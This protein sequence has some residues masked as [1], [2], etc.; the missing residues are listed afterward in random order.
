MMNKIK[1]IAIA[2][3]A[4][5]GIFSATLISCNPDNCKNVVCANGGTCN[6]TD[7][8]CSCASGY[9]GTLCDSLSITK[10]IANYNVT[11]SCQSSYVASITTSS[12]ANNKVIISNIANL[13]TVNPGATVIATCDK[14]ALTITRQFVTG[15]S[16]TEVEGNGTISGNTLTMTYSVYTGG[17]IAATCTSTSWVKQ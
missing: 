8:S 6:S 11:A 5:V 1:N 2:A 12:A 4:T 7:G 16:T 3:I 9:E 13:N 10:F 17:T 14:S 15:L